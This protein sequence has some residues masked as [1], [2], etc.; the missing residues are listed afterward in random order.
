MKKPVTLFLSLLILI[1]GIDA[2]K[3]KILFLGNSYTFGNDL[4]TMIQDLALSFGDT[5]VKDQSTPG[6]H[7]FNAHLSNTTSI[8]KINAQPWD[9]VVLQEQSQ[10]PSLPQSITGVDY[11]LPHSISLN[12]MIKNNHSCTETVFFM[13]WGRQ[14]GDASFCGQHPPVCTYDGMQQELRNM[15][16]WMA[17]TNN[18]TVSPVGVAW[19]NVRDSFPTINLY[20]GDGSHPN[21]KG[22]YLAA[23]VFYA[24]LYQKSPIGTTYI[25]SGITAAEALIFQTVA[26]NTVLD[27]M[28]LWRINANHPTA[29][30][31]FSGGN[32]VSFT[33]TSTNGM[34]YYWDFDDGNFSLQQN[35]THSFL[36]TG[37]YNV[38]LIV[39]SADSCFNDTIIKTIAVN[40]VGIDEKNLDDEVKIYPNPT[41]NIINIVADKPITL[42][43]LYDVYGRK[44]M[45]SSKS[46]LD[47]SNYP[48]GI[49]LMQIMNKSRVI[50]RKQ[51]IK[52]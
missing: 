52:E 26:S 7:Y 4:P 25:P 46:M 50:S 51:V 28:E 37:N 47:L 45:E 6:G 3:K 40:S 35:P 24:T 31:N 49:Y 42:I 11:C 30:F 36:T 39:Y 15:Y 33:S 13:T 23:C 43:E 29:D 10:I 20:T 9:F 48:K 5:I 1:G 38:K 19:K 14:N 34:H 22:S 12:N 2:Q 18:A 21:I 17:D 41:N 27:S 32:P 44:V 8:T 16:M